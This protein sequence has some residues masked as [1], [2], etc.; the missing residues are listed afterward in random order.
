MRAEQTGMS[1]I[2]IVKLKC[3]CVHLNHSLLW[4][5]RAPCVVRASALH[6]LDGD[7]ESDFQM[8]LCSTV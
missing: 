3:A 8:E 5:I 6:S 2:I 1:R 7:L 4:K